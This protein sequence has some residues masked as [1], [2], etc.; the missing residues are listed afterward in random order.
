MV[1][2]APRPQFEDVQDVVR[3]QL[4]R[5]NLLGGGAAVALS[6]FLAACSG[7]G[8]S[9]SD[10]PA[11]KPAA[12]KS[13]Q[14]GKANIPTPRDQTLT[15]AQV[16]YT[17]FDSWNRLIPNGAPSSA[18]LESLAMESLF[19]LNLATGELKSWLATEYKYNDDHTELTFKLNPKAKWSDG[20]PFTSKD[21]KF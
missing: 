13:V 2:D 4:S 12:T 6:G 21:V 8:G 5:R 3:Y 16:E 15:V 14:I 19:Y 1:N 9:Y 17:V 18:G 10:K 7:S 11:N 20:K